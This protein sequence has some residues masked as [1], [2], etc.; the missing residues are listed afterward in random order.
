MSS[1]STGQNRLFMDPIYLFI[2]TILL[3]LVVLDLSVG[4]ANDAVN[5]LNSSIGSKAAHLHLSTT[6]VTFMVAMGSSLRLH[7]KRRLT[8]KANATVIE[9]ETKTILL[10]SANLMKSQRN[11]IQTVM[12]LSD[13]RIKSPVASWLQT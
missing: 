1:A 12:R 11:M 10:Q 7:E 6:Y 9:D 13:E 3:G 4:V 2:V 5:F 8:G